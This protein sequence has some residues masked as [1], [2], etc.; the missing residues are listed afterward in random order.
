[1]LHNIAT[2]YHKLWLLEKCLR[3][4]EGVIF[5]LE[6]HLH[7]LQNSVVSS[8]LNQEILLALQ[9]LEMKKMLSNYC[10]R[11]CALNSQQENHKEA[12]N[13]ARKAIGYIRNVV[14]FD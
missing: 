3:Y 5:N 6:S 8:S 4:I 2:A 10:L 12:L 1:V 11:F 9:G 14:T 7:S 13:S